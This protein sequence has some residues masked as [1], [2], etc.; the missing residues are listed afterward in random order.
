MKALMI[1]CALLLAGSASADLANQSDWSGGPGTPGPV[2]SWGNDFSCDTAMNWFTSPGLLRLGG[3]VPTDIQQGSTDLVVADLD[4]DG[5]LDMAAADY[6]SNEVLWLENTEASGKRWTEHTVQTGFSGAQGLAVADF[7]DD[8]DSDIACSSSTT[9]NVRW[10]A[11]DGTGQAWTVHLVDNSAGAIPSISAADVNGDGSIDLA[12]CVP[13]ASD[14]IWWRNTASGSVWT[15]FSVDMS[16]EGAWGI[17]CDDMDSDGIV[18]VVACGSGTWVKA[19][20]WWDNSEGSGMAWQE[21]TIDLKFNGAR[22]LAVGDMDGDGDLDVVGAAMTDDDVFWWENAGGSGSSWIEHTVDSNL[23]GAFSVAL[24]DLD[25]NYDLDIVATSSSDGDVF[26]YSNL[27]GLGTVW[28]K[29]EL[30]GNLPQA[31]ALAAADL[32]Q[33]GS[34]ELLTGGS[35]QTILWDFNEFQFEGALESSILD[36]QCDPEWGLILWSAYSPPGTQ[37]TF[38][39][40]SS[41]DPAAMGDWSDTMAAPGQLGSFVPDGDRYFQYRVR[42]Q[43]TAPNATPV[44][45]DVTIAWEPMLGVGG[46]EIPE[47]FV[48]L[49]VTPNPVCGSFLLNFASPGSALVSFSI[50]DLSGRLVTSEGPSMYEPGW[51]AVQMEKLRP[52]VYFVLMQADGFET[53]RRFVVLE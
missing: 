27:D 8:G 44:L 26:W 32:D 24:A 3:G 47:A 12:G 5:D 13:G 46:G 11:N 36:T 42:F 35:P 43:S 7:D 40:R 14:V 25:W 39:F 22:G 33:D 19:I 29:R 6:F 37:V 52:G 48:L 16:F 2:V 49:P 50:L 38:R 51:H 30:T 28:E 53:S 31:T 41:D 45:Q 10:W 20:A 9:S 34:A 15:K 23:D 21:H 18:D 4:G 1:G 17:V